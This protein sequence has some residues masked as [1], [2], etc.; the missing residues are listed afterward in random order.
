M[1]IT[2]IAILPPLAF[3]R[4]G[5]HP[6]PVDN[7]TLETPKGEDDLLGY[8]RIIPEPTFQISADGEIRG[9]KTPETITFKE[10]GKVR[11]VA[12]FFELWAEFDDG[13]FE[14]L[15]QNMLG[16]AKLEWCVEVENRKVFR[17]TYNKDDI[18]KTEGEW[19]SDHAPHKLEG[20]CKNFVDGA[21]IDFG[22]VR[23]IKPNNDYPHI[24]L[25]VMPAAGRIYGSDKPLEN[26]KEEFVAA[27]VYKGR[28]KDAKPKSWV[29]WEHER[30]KEDEHDIETVPPALFAIIPPAPPW[31]NRDIAI[32]RGYLDD[33]CDGFV[34]AKLTISGNTICPKRHRR[35]AAALRPRHVVS[36]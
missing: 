8:R 1:T 7:Y 14:H 24:R 20:K 13:R 33:A 29:R 15:K 35:R 9:K 19:F 11:P 28:A 23:Y 2:R 21:S 30:N 5:S 10:N 31:L 25:R 36:S 32:S 27:R 6:E 4:F 18:V 16:D 12:P 34:R 26:L 3:A 22:E 17:R